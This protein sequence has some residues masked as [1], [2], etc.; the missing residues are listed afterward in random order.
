[1][2]TE[3]KG[4]WLSPESY[5]KLEAELEEMVTVR[6]AEI[7]EKIDAARQEGDLR[8]NGAYHAAREEQSLLEGRI[9]E[10]TH[11]LETA[12]VSEPPS[13]DEVAPGTIVTAKIAGDKERFLIG[14]R[15]L[16]EMVDIEVYP[17]AAP[18]GQAIIGLKKG[19]KTSFDAPSGAK[20]EVEI[21]DIETFEG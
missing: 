7:A 13:A 15:E 18:L 3:T 6:R 9:E 5:R 12:E 20:I 21:L 14:S 11:L 10:L 8:E 16:T 2:A 19:E 4:A 17:E 1:M